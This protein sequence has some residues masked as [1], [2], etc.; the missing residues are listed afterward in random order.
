MRTKNILLVAIFAAL[1]AIGAMIKIPLIYESITLQF[2]FTAL[3]G[4]LLGS[5]SGALSQF[6]Y[7]ILGMF[8]VPIFTQGGGIAYILKPTFGYLIGFI[9]SSY[10]IG[11]I[12]ESNRQVSFIVLFKASFIGLIVT[13][14]IGVPY[15]YII[16]KYISHIHITIFDSIKIGCLVFL[17][18]DL[19][20]C[21][22]TAILGVRIIPGIK[23][24][25]K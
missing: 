10:I 4:M 17:I 3:S 13:Y 18:G 22:V 7:V 8:G 1:T 23:D 20:K 9:F 2:L 11:K 24:M 6:V 12:I 5:K 16:L 14:V 25:Y 19:L 15:L 21:F